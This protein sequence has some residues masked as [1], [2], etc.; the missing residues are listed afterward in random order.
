MF[1]DLLGS[2]L[3]QDSASLEN[4]CAGLGSN[5][6]LQ[7]K[8]L[9]ASRVFRLNAPKNRSLAV[10]GVQPFASVVPNRV[11]LPPIAPH[12]ELVECAY[13]NKTSMRPLL[14]GETLLYVHARFSVPLV[15]KCLPPPFSDVVLPGV[16]LLAS[17]IEKQPSSVMFSFD[18]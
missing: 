17:V 11:T 6:P 3:A 4:S 12:G 9:S 1:L 10:L 5:Q 13:M 7:G 16:V 2:C 14:H 18:Q 15:K 8:D